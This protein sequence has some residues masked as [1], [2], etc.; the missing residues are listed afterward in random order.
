MLIVPT[1]NYVSRMQLLEIPYAWKTKWPPHWMYYSSNA[2]AV[3]V[4]GS[5]CFVCIQCRL[6][7]QSIAF[8]LKEHLCSIFLC[9][10]AL[11]FC[12]IS[13]LLYCKS[14]NFRIE[15]FFEIWATT[16]IFKHK[17]FQWRKRACYMYLGCA[18]CVRS[19]E[20][21]YKGAW[22]SLLYTRPPRTI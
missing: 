15:N 16:K 5:S 8:E 13:I 21:Y 17:I 2:Y 10:F 22:K 19:L 4:V 7:L 12:Y 14:G 6:H 20:F 11:P 9:F 3:V 18:C 1:F